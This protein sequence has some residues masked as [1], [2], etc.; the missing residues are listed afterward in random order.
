[1]LAATNPAENRR[2][3]ELGPMRQ[4]LGPRKAPLSRSRRTAR[5][6]PDLLRGASTRA[7]PPL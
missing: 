4:E 1:V 2:S 5:A 7:F 3:A 6:A